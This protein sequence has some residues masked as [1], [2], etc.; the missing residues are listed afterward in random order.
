MIRAWLILGDLLVSLLLLCAFVLF[1]LYP[2]KVA[3]KK[4]AEVN[5]PLQEKSLPQPLTGVGEAETNNTMTVEDF[6]RLAQQESR[7]EFTPIEPLQ[8]IPLEKSLALLHAERGDPVFIRIFKQE[9]ILEIWILVESQYQLLKTYKICAYSGTL[10]PKLKEGDRQ[11][12]EG[13]YRVGKSSLNPYSKFHLSFNL[14][15]PNTYDREH[16]RTGSYLMVHGNCVSTG[17]YAM[18]DIKMEEI[19]GMVEA[20]LQ[21]G[22]PFVPIHIYPFRMTEENMARYSHDRWYDFWN[23]LKD[24][25][26]YFEELQI[27]PG[28]RVEEG[29]YLI[30]EGKQ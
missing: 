18:T 16:G 22:Q 7:L 4:R 23:N 19:Y 29:R 17:C 2:S 12:P 13:F 28:I 9:A 8:D 15:Y 27:P 10:G 1:Y 20:A 5:L 6:I 11:A 25:Y 24:G 14:G 26:D 30:V 3:V 21:E